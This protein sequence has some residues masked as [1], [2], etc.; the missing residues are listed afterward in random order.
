VSAGHDSSQTKKKPTKRQNGIDSIVN[1][2]IIIDESDS[3][4]SVS[5]ESIDS[6]TNLEQ[7]I[8]ISPS[9]LRRDHS[10]IDLLKKFE[11]I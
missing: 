2:I 3:S 10:L 6:Q 1:D 8:T 11:E 7:A 5:F 4:R 9:K